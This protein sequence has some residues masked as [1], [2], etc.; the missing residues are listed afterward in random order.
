MLPL[1]HDEVVHG[2]G[3]LIDRMPGDEWQRFA[4]LRLLFGYMYTHP[5]TKLLFMGGEF[6]Q[7]TEWNIEKG[8]QWWLLDHAPHQGVQK[9]VKRLNE[10]YGEQPAL[11]ERQFTAEGF[12][13]I[14]HGDSENSFLSYLRKGEDEE[15][16]LVVLCNFTPATKWPYRL[17]VPFGGTWR[18]VLN[19]DAEAFGGSGAHQNTTHIAQ[20]GEWAGRSHYIEV[21]VSP[22]AI[23]VFERVKE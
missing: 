13:W 10:V 1:S 17:A 14:D 6:G 23:M 20:K 7:T 11:Y 4:N 21:S 2:K 19:S 3:A 15:Y 18:E 5:G 12:E 22:L 8:L 16:P 9:W